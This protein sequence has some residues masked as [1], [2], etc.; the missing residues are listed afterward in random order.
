MIFWP[1]HCER[2]GACCVLRGCTDFFSKA[3]SRGA[4]PP[5]NPPPRPPGAGGGARILRTGG[6][7]IIVFCRAFVV[8]GARGDPS[9]SDKVLSL[10]QV[11]RPKADRPEV[12]RPKADQ[13]STGTPS[14]RV[15]PGE[16]EAGD[17][18][19]WVLDNPDRGPL[20]P[21]QGDVVSGLAKIIVREAP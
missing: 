2:P 17:V 12:S 15:L 8:R 18:R 19:P 7:C 20:T 11:S 3:G 5:Y 9:P 6:H 13:R 21:V 1:H 16:R 10:S 4:K 14:S